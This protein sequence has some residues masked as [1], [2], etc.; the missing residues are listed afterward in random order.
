MLGEDT[1]DQKS[2]FLKMLKVWQ[3]SFD[4]ARTITK[5]VIAAIHGKCIGGGIDLITA[6]DI[7]LCSEDACFSIKEFVFFFWM[8]IL[9]LEFCF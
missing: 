9:F 1:V 5:P 8:I 2:A 6:C 4:R 7:R 3:R